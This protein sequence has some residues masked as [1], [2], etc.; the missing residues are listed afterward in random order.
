MKAA[1]ALARHLALLLVVS[2]PVARAVTPPA[3][4]QLGS[5]TFAEFKAFHDKMEGAHR[6]R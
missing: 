2:M 6:G 1:S 5:V 3:N 4:E